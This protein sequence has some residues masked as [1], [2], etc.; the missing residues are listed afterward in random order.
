MGEPS[1]ALR[2]AVPYVVHDLA[3]LFTCIVAAAATGVRDPDAREG[4][5]RAIEDA[6]ARGVELLALLRGRAP[7]ATPAAVADVVGTCGVL[8][9]HL[10]RRTDVAVT[11]A[12][13]PARVA[14]PPH[15]LQEIV[16]NLGLNAIE[17]MPAGGAV[18]IEACVDG[19]ELRLVVEDDGPGID[20]ARL[21]TL[22]DDPASTKPGH[23]GLGLVAVRTIVTRAGGRV[24]AA[25][26]TRGS[27]FVV[28]LPLA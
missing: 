26:A 12:A 3:N 19:A 27:R 25:I 1:D 21:A 14:L 5:L 8:L 28:H 11:V 2:A 23:G 7:R 4:S 9:G 16:L 6:A 17:A 10:G 20:P 22:F 18:H 15:E 13:E 24:A